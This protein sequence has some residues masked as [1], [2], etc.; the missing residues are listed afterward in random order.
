V[1]ALTLRVAER[2]GMDPREVARMDA[3]WR[4][5]LLGFERLRRAE[6]D[7]LTRALA[8]LGVARA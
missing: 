3:G 4:A 1:L 7:A 8:S 2:F 6:E 5:Q